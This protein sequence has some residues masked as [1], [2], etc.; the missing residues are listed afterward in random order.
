[1]NYLFSKLGSFRKVVFFLLAVF[2]ALSLVR[3]IQKIRNANEKIDNAEKKLEDLNKESLLL[4]K[5]LKEVESTNFIVKEARDKLGLAKEGEIVLILP[6]DEVLRKLS[7]KDINGEEI[8][9]TEE[10][11]KEWFKLFF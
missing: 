9:L 4:Q 7:P 11:W 10:N 1:M 3:N 6:E 5:K 2:L 8:M